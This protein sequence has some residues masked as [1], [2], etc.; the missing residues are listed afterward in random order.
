MGILELGDLRGRATTLGNLGEFLVVTKRGPEAVKAYRDAAKLARAA[1][2]AP[3][4]ARLL[5][6]LA[7]A[8]RAA[9]RLAEAEAA[10][11]EAAELTG[12]RPTR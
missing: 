5:G 1:G 8:H 4:C 7:V 2:D 6:R 3:L 10:E 12:G 11:R 9:G